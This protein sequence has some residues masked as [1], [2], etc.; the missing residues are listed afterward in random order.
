MIGIDRPFEAGDRVTLDR[1]DFFDRY[2]PEARTI[3]DELLE[4]YAEHGVAQFVIPDV[5]KV[6]PVSERGSVSEIIQMF[7][8]ADELRSAVTELQ[9]LLYA[10]A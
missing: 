9:N 8:G 7:G 5:L 2:G 1:K 10:A 6:P 4:K 3:L